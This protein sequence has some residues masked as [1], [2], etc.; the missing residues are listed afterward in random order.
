MPNL[1]RT[2]NTLATRFVRD[3]LAAVRAAVAEDLRRGYEPVEWLRPNRRV[4][5]AS[6]IFNA[7]RATRGNRTKAARLLGVSR[8]TFY[9]RLAEIEVR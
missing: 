4:L 7:L 6:D 1:D 5:G 8:R 2:L 9:N 3:V